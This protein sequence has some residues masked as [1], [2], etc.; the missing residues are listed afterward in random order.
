ML[1]SDSRNVIFVHVP[2]TG[3]MAIKSVLRDTWGDAHHG[4][5]TSNPIYN[6]HQRAVRLRNNP[7]MDWGNS[8]SFSFVRN[9]WDRAVSLWS[10]QTGRNMSFSDWFDRITP[11]NFG[12]KGRFTAPQCHMVCDL[13]GKILVSKIGRFENFEADF[14]EISQQWGGCPMPA[15]INTSDRGLYQQYY[16]SEMRDKVARMY[17]SD[18]ETFGYSFES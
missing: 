13:D 9:P 7:K 5:M 12:P 8:F 16:S 2:R 18:I 3:G 10:H 4:G 11:E 15:K 1:K 6:A 17:K 14:A